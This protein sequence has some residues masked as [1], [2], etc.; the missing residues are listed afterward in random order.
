MSTTQ[1][2]AETLADVVMVDYGLGNLRSARRGLERAGANVVVSDDP[3]DF[4]DAD[5]IV[6]P[7]VGAFS[8]GMD[9][10]GPFRE[11]LAE[12]AAAGTPIFGICLGMQMLLT[13]SEEADHAGEGEVEGLDFIP[14]RNVRFDEGQKVPHMGWNELHAQR[15]HPIVEGV[16]G[17]YAYFV[18]SY[19][20][21]PDDENAV[22]A[23][24]DYG[25]E[26]PAIVANEEGTVF[27]TQ[28]HPEK[29]G[30]TGLTILRNFVE[31]C[32]NQ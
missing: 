25:V 27:G 19:Y 1:A 31:F 12:A 23:T 3:T 2:T 5:G 26:F 20:A 13:S 24:T 18:H 30:E 4:E 14:G 11:P 7:G 10:A 28:F 8:E 17:E 29:S 9:N 32:A 21:D 22:V 15:D 16:D 6:L